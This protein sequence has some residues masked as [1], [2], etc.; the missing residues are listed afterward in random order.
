M[1]RFSI[2]PGVLCMALA[3]IAAGCGDDNNNASSATQFATTA[4]SGNNV[5]PPNNSGG[6]GSATFD[7]SG[8]T[9]QFSVSLSGVSGVTLVHLHSGAPAGSGPVRVILFSD[10]GT[11]PVNG[12]LISDSFLEADVLGISFSDLINEM[13]NGQVYMDVHTA[14]FPDGEVRGQVQPI[15]Q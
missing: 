7:M 13:R 15:A 2:V 4:V 1:R 3:L 8:N 10:P 11:G 14:A 9:V 6:T 12:T 5:I